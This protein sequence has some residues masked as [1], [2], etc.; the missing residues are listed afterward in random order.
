[1]V[2]AI[3][4]LLLLVFLAA[5]APRSHDDIEAGKFGVR[6]KGRRLELHCVQC[7]VVDLR[8][9]LRHKAGLAHR[10]LLISARFCTLTQQISSQ[11]F[12]EATICLQII[13]QGIEC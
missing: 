10:Q 5:E 11:S 4:D 8:V 2:S 1:M 13:N 7:C 6:F 3:L 12:S 9:I